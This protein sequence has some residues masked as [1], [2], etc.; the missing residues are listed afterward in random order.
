MLIIINVIINLGGITPAVPTFQRECDV[1]CIWNSHTAIVRRELNTEAKVYAVIGR[2]IQHVYT[3][4]VYIYIYYIYI[5]II[6]YIQYHTYPD[7]KIVGN[8]TS[9]SHCPTTLVSTVTAIIANSLT[10]PSIVISLWK[11]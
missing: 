2:D 9:R 8:R 1:Q 6:I 3:A 4:G 11:I 5:Y 7:S 10:A